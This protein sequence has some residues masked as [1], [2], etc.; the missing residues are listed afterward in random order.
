MRIKQVREAIKND[1]VLKHLLNDEMNA[2]FESF[3]S[4]VLKGEFEEL[5]DVYLF[6]QAGYD[7]HGLPI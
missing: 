7:T 2:Y 6:Q 1:P 3:E 5:P 4:A